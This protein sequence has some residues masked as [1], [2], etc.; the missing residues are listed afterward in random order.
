MRQVRMS[1]GRFA[2]GTVMEVFAQCVRRL[3]AEIHA[4][5]NQEMLSV[6]RSH[7]N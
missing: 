4:R 3:I 5:L 6:N 7:F 2:R 1:S